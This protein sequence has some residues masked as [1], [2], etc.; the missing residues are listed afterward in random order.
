MNLQFENFDIR[1]IFEGEISFVIS[2]SL[3]NR[4]ESYL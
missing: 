4:Y 3:Y 1:V 2:L